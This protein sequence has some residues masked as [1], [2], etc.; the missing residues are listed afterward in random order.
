[1]NISIESI[2]TKHFDGLRAALGSVAREKRFL[3][4]TES[5]PPEQ[6]RAFYES[7]IANGSIL[8]VA[9][10]DGAIVGWCDVL[11]AYGQACAHVGSLGMGV[12]AD[13]RGRGIGTL[14]LT[15]AIDAARAAGLTRIELV[16]RVDNA[17]ATALYERHGFVVEG[18]QRQAFRVDGVYFDGVAMALTCDLRGD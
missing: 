2:A 15:S 17:S 16:V 3:A 11:P 8:L 10:L 7:V 4:F 13:A 5:P 6:S 12:I 9:V 18:R 1:M 14:L